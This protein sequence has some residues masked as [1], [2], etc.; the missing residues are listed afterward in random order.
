MNHMNTKRIKTIIDYI[1]LGIT[2]V[3]LLVFG[4]HNRQKFIKLLPSLI[5]LGV[6]LL[7]S[8]ANKWTFFIGALNALLYAVGYIM[9]GV[10]ASALSAV[11]VSFPL[12]TASFFRWKK[13]SYR[14][15]TKFRKMSTRKSVVLYFSSIIACIAMYFIIGTI[16]SSKQTAFDVMVFV[17]GLYATIL[18]M[19]GYMEALLFS[20]VNIVS[21]ILLW[22]MTVIDGNAAN[23]T[24]VISMCF[25]CYC[26]I[27]MCITW[28]RLYKEQNN[29][30]LEILTEKIGE[31]TLNV[32]KKS[33]KKC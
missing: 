10:Y 3:V 32:N 19:L 18:T 2:F 13:N 30:V 22:S 15:S 24:Y 29:A 12:Q 9:E 17:F 8:K 33:S 23:I 4:I 16:P 20:I 11:V 27:N 25:N 21:N 28:R 5:S 1:L 14:Q 7:S 26:T 31:T 6:F